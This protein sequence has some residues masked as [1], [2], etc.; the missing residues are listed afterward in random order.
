MWRVV[1]IDAYIISMLVALFPG[2]NQPSLQMRLARVIALQHVLCYDT[3]LL[4]VWLGT[5]C[6]VHIMAYNSTHCVTHN[7]YFILVK[8][9]FEPY[10]ALPDR[11]VAKNRQ[12]N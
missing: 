9:L 8:G 4:Q 12:T 5:L 11:Q 7:V 3:T 6:N 10:Q 1:N 2:S